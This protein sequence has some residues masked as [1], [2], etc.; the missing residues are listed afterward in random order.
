V[1][2]VQRWTANVS[3]D[4]CKRR[5]KMAGLFT[6]QTSSSDELL[7]LFSRCFRQAVPA[8]KRTGECLERS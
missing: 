1:Q 3:D 5:S 8:W 4:R 7:D 2:E 6:V